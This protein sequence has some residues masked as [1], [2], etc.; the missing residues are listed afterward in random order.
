T[1]HTYIDSDERAA[2]QRAKEGLALYVGGMGAKGA[3]FHFDA[4][5]RAGFGDAATKI[6]D[7][8]LA[9]RREE[10]VLAVP[11]EL[12]DGTA[13]LGS[14]KRIAKRLESW[15]SSPI[16]TVVMMGVRDE[17]ELRALASEIDL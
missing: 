2:F 10:A 14:P 17:E 4:V 5:T 8:Y 6:Q 7:L 13:L 3:N 15:R 12:V 1:V 11:D 16:N 9:G